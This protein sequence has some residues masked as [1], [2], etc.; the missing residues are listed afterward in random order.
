MTAPRC[1][2]VSNS[3][4]SNKL[5]LAGKEDDMGAVIVLFRLMV[6]TVAVSAFREI[7]IGPE[8]GPEQQIRIVVDCGNAGKR[9]FTNSIKC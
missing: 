7:S 5:Q 2:Q 3:R 9:R 4:E 1:S 8:P 6:Q